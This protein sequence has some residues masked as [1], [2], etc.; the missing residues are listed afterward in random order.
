LAQAVRK[1]AWEVQWQ[2]KW[3][4]AREHV[5]IVMCHR[6]VDVTEPVPLEVELE[7]A[8]EFDDFEDEDVV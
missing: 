8:E 7:E 1:R 5:Q 2:T 4:A 6:I 3:A